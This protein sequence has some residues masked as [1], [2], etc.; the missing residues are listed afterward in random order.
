MAILGQS[1][2]LNV[3]QSVF[4]AK[5]PNFMAAECISLVANR[6]LLINTYLCSNDFLELITKHE[7]HHAI[8]QNI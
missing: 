7:L 3:C 1:A 2:Q 8:K 5:L 4:V 6:K